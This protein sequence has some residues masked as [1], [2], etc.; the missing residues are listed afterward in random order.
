[1]A[2]WLRSPVTQD[3]HAIKTFH[4]G[5]DEMGRTLNSGTVALRVTDTRHCDGRE[6]SDCGGA[7]GGDLR[8][9]YD[10]G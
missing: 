10:Q 6:M 3:L 4:I 1:M 8:G 5:L 2:R 9:G 7:T